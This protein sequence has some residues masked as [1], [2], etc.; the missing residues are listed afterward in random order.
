[1]IV[2]KITRQ[3][4]GRGGKLPS[5]DATTVCTRRQR[6]KALAKMLVAEAIQATPL[7]RMQNNARLV[8][9]LDL[10]RV[11]AAI[12]NGCDEQQ[13]LFKR[14]LQTRVIHRIQTQF[15][16][17]GYGI[18]CS[19]AACDQRGGR[20][21]PCRGT[22]SSPCAASI[23]PFPPPPPPLTQT[24]LG[25]SAGGTGLGGSLTSSS[26]VQIGLVLIIL[27]WQPW[28]TAGQPIEE[29]LEGPMDWTKACLLVPGLGHCA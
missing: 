6:C 3:P 5:T 25:G 8:R 19:S 29:G 7:R 23:P 17:V 28:Q 1:M 21:E 14:V 22:E 15:S 12:E 16:E 26:M 13:D 2:M 18:A 11:A 24:Q 4:G 9:V 27:G 20:G 10:H